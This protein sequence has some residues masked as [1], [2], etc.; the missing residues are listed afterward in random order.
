MSIIIGK[1][2][3]AL[4]KGLAGATIA[5]ATKTG[6]TTVVNATGL[7]NGASQAAQTAVGVGTTVASVG[8]GCVVV[9]KLVDCAN[10][11]Q[12]PSQGRHI[13]F[14]EPIQI[15]TDKGVLVGVP[16]HKKNDNKI[17]VEV[18]GEQP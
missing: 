18:M 9:D 13:K 8:V 17:V 16:E 3:G 5:S 11:N 10:A 14:A 1:I 7:L 12:T 6:L 15:Y 2:C 4:V